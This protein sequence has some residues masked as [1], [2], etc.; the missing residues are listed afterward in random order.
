MLKLFVSLQNM[1]ERL[2]REEGQ[3]AV[4]YGL[5]LAVIAVAIVIAM[6][7]GLSGVADT[8]VTKVTNAV[9]GA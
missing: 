8:V 6:K 5:V 1:L 7:T 4:E 2:S 3:T 9:N